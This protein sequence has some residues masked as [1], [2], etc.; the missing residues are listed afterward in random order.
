MERAPVDVFHG[1]KMEPFVLA[2]VIDSN[3]CWMAQSCGCACFSLKAPHE[4][5][6]EAELGSHHFEGHHTTKAGIDGP[7][8]TGHA[9]AADLF[10]NL[11]VAEVPSDKV[12]HRG[13]PLTLTPTRSQGERESELP[14]PLGAGWGEGTVEGCGA[15]NMAKVVFSS[16]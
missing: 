7:I 4:F 13:A 10:Q 1:N 9:A 8:D 12:G 16:L 15:I 11:K 2:N 6:V 3:D 14:L 5:W